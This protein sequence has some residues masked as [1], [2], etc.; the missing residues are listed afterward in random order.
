MDSYEYYVDSLIK[1]GG[2][3]FRVF[4]VN[5]ISEID[6]DNLGDHWTV[7]KDF[8]GDIAD[9]NRE[10]YGEGKKLDIVIEAYVEPNSITV[11]GVDVSGNPHEKEVNVKDGKSIVVKNIYEYD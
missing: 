7:G 1:N 5:D 3:I 11:D 8:I 6:M 9:N 10:Y 4:F 2:S